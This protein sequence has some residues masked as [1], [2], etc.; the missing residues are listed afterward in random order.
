MAKTAGKRKPRAAR[1]A[2]DISQSRWF[3]WALAS[4]YLLILILLF[5]SFVFS[6]QMLYGSDTLQAQVYMKDLHRQHFRWSD[7]LRLDFKPKWSPYLFG[8]MPFVDSFNSDIL[9][10]PS[11]VLKFLLPLDLHRALGW[12]LILHFWL[13]GMGMYWCAHRGWGIARWPAAI[14][15]LAYMLAPYLISMVHPGHDGKIFVVAWFPIGFLLLKQLW[16]G[17][18][19]RHVGLFGLVVGVII[20]TPHVQMAYFSLWAYASYSVYRI[21]LALKR[22]RRLPWASSAG[23]LAAV[24]VAVGMSAWQFYPGYHYVKHHSPRAGEGRGFEYAS[25]WSLHPEELVSEVVADFSGVSGKEGNTYWGRNFFKDNTEY[26]GLVVLLLALYAVF[27]TRFRDRWFFFGLGIFAV[28][29]ALGGHTPLF[30]LFYH[31]VPNVKQMRAPSMIMFLYVFSISLCAGAALH[32]LRQRAPDKIGGRGRPNVLWIAAMALGG[33]ALLFTIAPGG[34]MS[35][36]KA[37]FYSGITPERDAVLAQHLDAIVL[38]L[39]LAALMALATAWLAP[40]LHAGHAT[41]VLAGIAV[42][43]IFDDV[44]M[45]RRFIQTIDFDQ[46]Y[47]RDPVVDFLHSQPGPLRVLA[48]PRGFPTNYFALMKIPEMTGYHGNQLRTYNDFLGGPTQPRAFTRRALDLASVGYLVFRRGVNLN[49][50]PG[51]PLLQK[52]YEREGTVVF[53]NLAALPWARLVTCWE[54]HDPADTLYERLWASD[55]DY[56]TCVVVDEAPPFESSLDTSFHD[57]ATIVQYDLEA[58]EIHVETDR[59]ALLVFAEN[60]YPAWRALLDGQPA[61][62]LKTN[63]T[64]R[65]VPVPAGSHS[66]R[67]EYRSNRL[68][69]GARVTLASVLVALA[70]VFSDLLWRRRRKP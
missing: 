30:K 56:R 50:D 16:E 39:W 67:F 44:R 36:Y 5:S 19:L 59:D 58:V 51:D 52:V 22:D 45:D 61:R 31:V 23:A 17:V 40:Q 4:A 32:E 47:R 9:N 48:P 27:R 46:Y 8:G 26:G 18:R 15:G 20:L 63:A 33:A 49:Q 10:F 24:V 70:M 25:S 38:S 29:Y 65:G 43:I 2:R 37:V 6:D 1:A 35:A 21:V 7:I 54:L 28:L 66:V 13:A 41:W 53:Q 69:A 34:M 55:F 14:S 12:M 62:M 57:T 64:F 3:P 11:Y 68:V 42:V 60:I